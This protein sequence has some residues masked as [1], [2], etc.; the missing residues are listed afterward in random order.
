V[1]AQE[2]DAAAATSRLRVVEHEG[3]AAPAVRAL[4]GRL[5]PSWS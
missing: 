5:L 4:L 3:V 1:A 2:E